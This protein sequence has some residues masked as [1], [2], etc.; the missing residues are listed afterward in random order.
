MD[1]SASNPL[2][3]IRYTASGM[4][5]YIHSNASFL[6]ESRARSRAVGHFLSDNTTNPSMPPIETPPLNGPVYTSCKFL[7]TVVG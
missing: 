4:V 3:I 5:L 6:S 2:V 1:Y 7:D